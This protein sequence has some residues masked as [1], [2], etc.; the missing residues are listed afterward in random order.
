MAV[1][2]N[3]AT[4]VQLNH[5]NAFVLQYAWQGPFINRRQG[6]AAD[7]PLVTREKIDGVMA[8]LSRRDISRELA[9][10]RSLLKSGE[11]N[12]P[13]RM[14]NDMSLFS[15]RNNLATEDKK[16]LPFTCE[17]IR[18]W[19]TREKKISVLEK[20]A[21]AKDW[22][23]ILSFFEEFPFLIY[24]ATWLVDPSMVALP[25]STDET[26][27]NREKQEYTEFVDAFLQKWTKLCATWPDRVELGLQRMFDYLPTRKTF[28]PRS[29]LVSAIRYGFVG[30]VELLTRLFGNSVGAL[31]WSCLFTIALRHCQPDIM[32]VIHGSV[33]LDLE[34]L[35]NAILSPFTVRGTTVE[36]LRMYE[37]LCGATAAIR[38][39]VC[40][41]ELLYTCC[42]PLPE[43][44]GKTSEK[45]QAGFIE[46]L[47][48]LLKFSEA[49][50]RILF[51]GSWC[52][53]SLVAARLAAAAAAAEEAEAMA[54]L[55]P[56]ASFPSDEKVV[57]GD[58]DD[59]EDDGILSFVDNEYKNMSVA[60]LRNAISPLFH[61]L[62]SG[63]Y[64]VSAFIIGLIRKELSDQKD[65]EE[66]E[67]MAF[68]HMTQTDA[69]LTDSYREERALFAAVWIRRRLGFYQLAESL[70]KPSLNLLDGYLATLERI[71]IC[72]AATC[73][74]DESAEQ[75]GGAEEEA[76]LVILMIGVILEHTDLLTKR[77]TQTR[78]ASG[79]EKK[80]EEED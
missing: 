42:T 62:S 52:C 80:E 16:L 25:L 58:D 29:P 45:M 22:A 5:A 63:L 64:T 3:H 14:T 66:E 33:S 49:G 54:D 79:K 72:D 32:R 18:L 19:D 73:L 47:E 35:E 55:T 50:A 74:L 36:C 48:H 12:L 37:E 67:R 4:A 10:P 51:Q 9:V 71:A 60:Q 17:G 44:P 31:S 11:F 53:S 77:N 56:V 40:E 1:R 23:G 21:D 38:N 70:S 41:T 39:R 57:D 34:Y 75:R 68:E 13:N 26:R 6:S 43:L 69:R 28:A 76:P 20:M 7:E 24:H 46:I 59:D 30:Y 15:V 2:L 61:A 8:S 65:A 27:R 78:M